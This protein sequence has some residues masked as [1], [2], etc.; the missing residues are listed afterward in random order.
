M[1]AKYAPLILSRGEQFQPDPLVPIAHGYTQWPDDAEVHTVFYDSSAG[2]IDQ[3]DGEVAANEITFSIPPEDIDVVPAG[4]PYETFLTDGEGI[5]TMLR[6][7]QVIRRQ[8]SFFTPRATE[9]A[10]EALQFR[11]NFYNRKGNPGPKW[12]TTFGRP[13][14]HDNTAIGLP[15]GVGALFPTVGG[16]TFT[17]QAAMRYYR[18]L[19]TDSYIV[20]FN[21]IFPDPGDTAI[22]V[23]SNTA[24]TSYSYVWFTS[25]GKLRMGSGTGPV[26]MVQQVSEVTHTFVNNTNYKLRYDNDTRKLAL[27]NSAMTTEL[28]S[29]TDSTGS[30][31]RGEGY[32][33]FG[34]NFQDFAI[35]QFQTR[36]PQ[37]T[38]ISA[39]DGF[40]V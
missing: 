12:F 32:R 9:F 13:T 35:L 38:Q 21:M 37:I 19:N 20:S 23:G 1:A 15:N 3:F 17:V 6:Y 26:T 31:P 24:M 25:T 4:A 33:Y 11:D 18:P 29:W 10:H 40:D 5:V 28:I 22:V 30:M 2:V 16:I 39:Q 27:L 14:I 36:G 8:A 7:G 34:M